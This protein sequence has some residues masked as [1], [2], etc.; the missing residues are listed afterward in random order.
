M[1]VETANKKQGEKGSFKRV[2][3]SAYKIKVYYSLQK[4]KI[5]MQIRKREKKKP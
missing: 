4:E 3:F 2:T 1:S 5:Q